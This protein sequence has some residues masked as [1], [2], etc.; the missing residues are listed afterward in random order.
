MIID[1]LYLYPDLGGTLKAGLERETKLAIEEGLLAPNMD[2][3]DNLL[4]QVRQSYILQTGANYE[5]IMEDAQ[6]ILDSIT[7]EDY[8]NNQQLTAVYFLAITNKIRP[9]ITDGNLAAENMLDEIVR[10]LEKMQD[11]FS[12]CYNFICLALRD[13]IDALKNYDLDTKP[14]FLKAEEKTA[15][16]YDKPPEIGEK[17]P[18]PKLDRLPALRYIETKNFIR[19][20]DKVS[21]NIFHS[22]RTGDEKRNIP[23]KF[24]FLT[25]KEKNGNRPGNVGIIYTMQFDEKINGLKISKELT[26]FDKRVLFTIASIYNA[27]NRFMTY[28]LIHRIMGNTTDPSPTQVEKIKKALINSVCAW[29]I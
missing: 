23:E 29:F 12:D 28:N 7:K 24:A 17:P 8:E 3:V 9:L 16:W 20:V 14:L 25:A 6:K 10:Q 27:G 5:R 2:T 26:F 1:T 19:A 13:Q 18:E 21:N 11:L 4:S 15:Q 22:F